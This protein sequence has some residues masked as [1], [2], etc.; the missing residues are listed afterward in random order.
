MLLQDYSP[1][2]QILFIEKL[3]LLRIKKNNE[4]TKIE[5][6]DNDEQENENLKFKL[7]KSCK[8]KD[9]ENKI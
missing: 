1:M 9:S 5:F 3:I 8:P 4:I 7:T 6:K 2:E